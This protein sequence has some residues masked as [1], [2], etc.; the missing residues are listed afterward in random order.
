VKRIIE[1]AGSAKRFDL[2]AVETGLRA[3]VL[4]AGAKALEGLLR[5]VGCGRRSEAV[6][7]S[8]GARM[9]STG[10]AAK[11]LL[12]I[13]GEVAFTRSRYEC[14]ACGASRHPGDEELGVSG[15]SRSPGLQRMMSRAGHRD[16]FKEGR[17]D[18]R[19]YA[20]VTVSAK[21]VERVA[22]KVGAEM[23]A[24]SAKERIAL[25]AAEAQEGARLAAKTIPIM[26]IEYDGTGVPMVPAAVQGRKGKQKDGSAKTREAKLGCV[27][28]QTGVDDEGRPARDPASTTFVGAIE[29]AEHFGERIYAEALR[30][31]LNHAA[32][33]VVLADGAPWI[34]GLA[35]M[36]FPQAI[37]IIDLYH[38]KEHV[39]DPAKMLWPNDEK[40]CHRNR[41]RWWTD[42]E[43]G[44]IENIIRAAQ[45]QTPSKDL[46]DN[47][48]REINYLSENKDR[49]RYAACRDQDLFVGSGVVEAGC[50]SV[51]GKRL[52]QSGMEWSVR[53]ANAIISL[54]CMH[55]SGRVEEFWE[56]RCA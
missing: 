16:T 25:L 8:C 26:Y 20:G 45:K 36:H 50:K 37:Q 54:R 19:V 52:K 30:R 21:D 18:L 6:M 46:A 27:F 38:A 42:L 32:K 29:T 23:E 41:L 55:L 56:S 48:R 15:T 51:I 53:G 3:A 2:E 49:M 1:R 24:W 40:Q 12:T 43:E 10:L 7:C 33:V 34:R 31:G 13:L 35:Q 5:G 44:K 47:V 28:T 4:A 17:E 14:P 22:E 39:A 9:Q 11:P